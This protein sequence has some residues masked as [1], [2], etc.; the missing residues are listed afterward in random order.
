[1]LLRP[2]AINQDTGDP[3]LVLG[4]SSGANPFVARARRR[5][6]SAT[7]ASDP[8]VPSLAAL[9]LED[10]L[11]DHRTITLSLRAQFAW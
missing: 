6:L 1:M 8:M 4:S 5:R 7:V 10:L 11:D 3:G 9:A 2:V